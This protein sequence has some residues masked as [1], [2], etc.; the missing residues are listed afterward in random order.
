MGPED[1]YVRWTGKEAVI[2]NSMKQNPCDA[3][4]PSARREILRLLQNLKFHR[5]AQELATGP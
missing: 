2:T 4:N 1:C 5:L 3:N